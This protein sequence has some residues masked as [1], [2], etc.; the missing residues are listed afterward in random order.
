[1][2]NLSCLDL[3]KSSTNSGVSCLTEDIIKICAS[4]KFVQKLVDDK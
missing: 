3:Y 2:N 4:I 1:M